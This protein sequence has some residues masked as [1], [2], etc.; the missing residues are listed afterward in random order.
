MEFNPINGYQIKLSFYY[1]IKEPEIEKLY[2]KYFNMVNKNVIYK[3]EDLGIGT[4]DGIIRFYDDSHKLLF[5]AVQETKRD[6][7]V[8]SV[9]FGRSLLQSIMYLGNVYYDTNPLGLD[10]FKGIFLDSARYFCYVSKEELDPVM[11]LFEPL[12]Y[13]YYRVQ[14]SQAYNIPDLADFIPVALYK[15]K[16]K[17]YQL[18]KEF[19]LD[20]FIK[21]LY[22]NNI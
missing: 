22:E 5:W 10:N 8:D 19:E 17:H 11:E 1:K 12:W 9:W 6:V 18:N 16:F 14:P 15:I 2:G 21:N 3:K 13:K 20:Q 4:T 7:G